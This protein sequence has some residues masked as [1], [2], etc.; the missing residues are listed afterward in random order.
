MLF[1]GGFGFAVAIAAALSLASFSGVDLAGA[2]ITKAK[3]FADLM[4]QR[5]P[6]HRTAAQLIKTKGKQFRMLAASNA[7]SEIPPAFYTPA[8]NVFAP[9]LTELQGP[10]LPVISPLLAQA[11]SFPPAIFAPGGGGFFFP[12]GGG[13]PPGG[14]GGGPPGTTPPPIVTP[15]TPVPGVPE[16]G[17]WMTMILGFTITGWTLRRRR[18]KQWTAVRS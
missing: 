2:A 14:G 8:V 7:P 6:G 10:F 17:T 12:G 18:S 3:S 9:P 4:R 1:A 15:P 13:G 5:S 11:P 16:P